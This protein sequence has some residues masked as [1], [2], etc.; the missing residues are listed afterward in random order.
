[1][2]SIN[3]KAATGGALLLGS[4]AMIGTLASGSAT[5]LEDD[6]TGLLPGGTDTHARLTQLNNSG[7]RGN[8]DVHVEGRRLNMHL[9][10]RRLVRDMPHA[11]HIHFGQQARNECPTVRDDANGDHRL[12]TAE[13]QPAYGPV[14]VSMTKRGPTGP[15]STLAVDRFPT[16]P[17]GEIHYDRHTRTQREVARGIRRGNAVVV[18]HGVDY[19][20]NHKYDFA[21]AGKSELDPA[22]PAEATDPVACGVLRTEGGLPLPPLPLNK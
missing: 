12:N 2:R 7:V 3:A 13:G 21:G 18:I 16:A 22:L 5:A 14:R 11:Q 4:V 8:S 9:D 10:A 1:M 19:N 17:N 15:G 20:H 6:P